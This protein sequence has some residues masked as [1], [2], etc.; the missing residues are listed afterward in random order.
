MRRATEEHAWISHGEEGSFHPLVK[1]QLCVSTDVP[2]PTSVRPEDV[3]F[4]GA[5]LDTY[6]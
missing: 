6:S 1:L 4:S 3:K 5:T 2:I